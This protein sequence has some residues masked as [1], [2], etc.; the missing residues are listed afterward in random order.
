MISN[1]LINKFREHHINNS[2]DFVFGEDEDINVYAQIPNK[3]NDIP[4]LDAV[5]GLD[6]FS[7][8]DIETYF[9]DI[10]IGDARIKV[11]N[12]IRTDMDQDSMFCDYCNSQILECNRELYY[13]CWNCYKDMCNL[14]FNEA[15]ATI[16]KQNGAIHYEQRRDALAACRSHYLQKRKII[17]NVHGCYCDICSARLNSGKLWSNVKYVGHYARSDVCEQCSLSEDGK[18]LIADNKLEQLEGGNSQLEWWSQTQFGSILDWIPL[19][20]DQD[21]NGILINCNNNSNLCGRL[22]LM[23]T[24]DHGRNG[25]YTMPI[26]WTLEKTLDT[27]KNYHENELTDGDGRK[28]EGWDLFYNVPIKRMMAELKMQI[29]YG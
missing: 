1:D 9:N 16:A 12:G 3:Y 24:D 20:K 27:I 13:Y 5:S 6:I 15:D 19:Y 14:C 2:S 18:K 17:M 29:H 7:P 21:Y 11:I 10:L 4:K 22:C 8:K 23:S 26:E 25:Y 28:L